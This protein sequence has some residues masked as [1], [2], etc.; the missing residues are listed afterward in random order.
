MS[1]AD[2][3]WYDGYD[4]V[5]LIA[6]V[7]GMVCRNA[8]RVDSTRADINAFCCFCLLPLLL[9]CFFVWLPGFYPASSLYPCA[10][11]PKAIPLIIL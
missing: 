11:T 2:G 7:H 9:L 3:F 1:F 10:Q 4:A 5:G 8:F 6:F